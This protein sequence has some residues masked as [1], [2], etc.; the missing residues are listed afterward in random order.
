MGSFKLSIFALFAL[1][2]LSVF[3]DV[4]DTDAEPEKQTF[5]PSLDVLVAASFPNSEVFGIKLVNGHATEA[6]LDF[7]NN[8]DEPVTLAFVAGA[9]SSLNPLPDGAHPSTAVIRNLT[10]LR[11]DIEI[12]PGEN[13][14]VPY[15]FTTDLNPQD[16]RLNLVALV[17]T[18]AGAIYQLSAYNGTVSVVEAPTSFFD[19]QIIFLYLFLLAAFAGT[20]YF[21]Y[22]TWIEPLFPQKRKG[23]RR[24][25]G[26]PKKVETPSSPTTEGATTTG[27]SKGYDESWIPEHHLNRPK[28]KRVQSGSSKS[29]TKAVE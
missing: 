22:I 21:V 15:S 24:A 10:N 12:G 6:I 16:L 2:A 23:G 27:A 1:R 4:V 18:P 20:L 7:T 8:E 11:Y 25:A 29:K 5:A 17:A 26:G 28:A 3:A 13:Q 9:L 19:P 14:V